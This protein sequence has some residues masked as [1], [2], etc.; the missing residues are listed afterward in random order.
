MSIENR[1]K[2]YFV[3]F[4]YKKVVKNVGGKRLKNNVES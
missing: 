2:W 4:Y 3:E 1:F